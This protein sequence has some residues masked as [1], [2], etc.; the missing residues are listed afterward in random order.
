MGR[1]YWLIDV[2]DASDG[3]ELGCGESNAGCEF[4]FWLEGFRSSLYLGLPACGEAA[5]QAN[6]DG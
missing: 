6:D 3:G 1:L 4:V 5:K 2:V